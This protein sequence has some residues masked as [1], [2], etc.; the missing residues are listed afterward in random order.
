[1]KSKS[2]IPGEQSH[3]KVAGRN[4]KTLSLLDDL[5]RINIDR[6]GGY[7]KAAHEETTPEP[8]VREVFYRLAIESRANV[9]T[10][11][12]EV[13]RLGGPPVT[14]STIMGKIYLHWLEGRNE[15]DGSD[16]PARL[17]ACARSELA[18][19]KAYQQALAEEMQLEEKVIQLLENQLWA[20][21]RAQQRLIELKDGYSENN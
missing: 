12:A 9:N 16:T 21:E 19:Q 8:E 6:I 20:L 4:K 13:I 7:E 3:W 2:Y 17:S 15:F 14:Q 11:H 18:I 5:I 10:L 1:M